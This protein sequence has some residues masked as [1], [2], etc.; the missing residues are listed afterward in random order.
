MNNKPRKKIPQ[1]GEGLSDKTCARTLCRTDTLT[2]MKNSKRDMIKIGE[3]KKGDCDRK[4]TEKLVPDFSK[5][6][7]WSFTCVKIKIQ[8]MQY[9]MEL[10]EKEKGDCELWDS[11]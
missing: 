6:K 11:M 9:G 7:P 3:G 10:S 1:V 5:Y 4:V 2:S 8:N